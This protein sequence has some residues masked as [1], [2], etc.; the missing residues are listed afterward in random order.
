MKK[1]MLVD[2]KNDQIKVDDYPETASEATNLLGFKEHQIIV[3]PIGLRMIVDENGRLKRKRKLH[4]V[5]LGI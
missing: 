2:V 5:Y 1:A 4:M 3:L